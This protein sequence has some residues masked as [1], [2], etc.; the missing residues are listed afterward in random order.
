MVYVKCEVC[1]SLNT[2]TSYYH[3]VSKFSQNEART[4]NLLGTLGTQTLGSDHPE[5]GLRKA[6]YLGLCF[7]LYKIG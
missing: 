4:L 6:F 7:F 2:C 5:C 1:F 3:F